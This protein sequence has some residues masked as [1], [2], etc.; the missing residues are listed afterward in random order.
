MPDKY[1]D[2]TRD[3]MVAR[4]TQESDAKKEALAA[5]GTIAADAAAMEEERRLRRADTINAYHNE[6]R[7]SARPT[8]EALQAANVEA[9]V[10]Y[11]REV[12][13]EAGLRFIRD[14]LPELLGSKAVHDALRAIARGDS[15]E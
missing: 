2:E 6:M 13:E 10:R 15:G 1:G 8:P 3:E 11:E 9:H 14:E 7:D 4:L 12:R 5:Q